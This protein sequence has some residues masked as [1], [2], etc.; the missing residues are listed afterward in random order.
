MLIL[1][2]SS[3]KYG[4]ILIVAISKIDEALEE[5]GRGTPRFER[6]LHMTKSF[7]GKPRISGSHHIFK[8]PWSDGPWI[9]LQELSG[10]TGYK[11]TGKTKKL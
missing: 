2:Q 3:T 1:H 6:L 11:G 10:K 7:F 8:L 4:T 5:L 9:N